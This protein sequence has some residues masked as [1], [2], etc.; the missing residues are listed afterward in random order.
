[1]L[2]RIHGGSERAKPTMAEEFQKLMI[3]ERR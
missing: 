2:D 1:M 3:S